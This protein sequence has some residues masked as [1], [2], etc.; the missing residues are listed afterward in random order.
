MRSTTALIQI[1]CQSYQN[2]SITHRRFNL[3][4][5]V[6]GI[7]TMGALIRS[8]NR[9]SKRVIVFQKGYFS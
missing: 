6:R 5:I 8:R 1:C 9:G 2:I 3:N 4:L 7:D